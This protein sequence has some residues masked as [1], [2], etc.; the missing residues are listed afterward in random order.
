MIYRLLPSPPSPP[1][2]A[3]GGGAIVTKFKYIYFFKLYTG[4]RAM[5]LKQKCS[6]LPGV[7][8]PPGCPG[9]PGRPGCP[10]CPGTAPGGGLQIFVEEV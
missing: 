5:E 7:A 6:L 10:G 8:P 9:C 3:S 4:S 1:S 2:P